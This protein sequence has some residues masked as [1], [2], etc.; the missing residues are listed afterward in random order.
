M[1]SGRDAGCHTMN[2]SLERLLA[3]HKISVEDARAATTDRVGF[4]DLV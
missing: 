1:N 4:A 2:A 3:G